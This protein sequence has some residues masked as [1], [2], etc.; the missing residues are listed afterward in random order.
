MTEQAVNEVE[1]LEHPMDSM[2]RQDRLPHIWC[3]GCGI[4]TAFSAVI[5]TIKKSGTPADKYAIVSGIGCS[6]RSAGYLKIDSFHTTH[7]RSIPFATG[8]KLVKPEMKVFVFAGDG[9]LFAIGGNHFIH[10]ARRNLD[11]TVICS[12]NYIYGM[13]GGQFSPGTPKDAISSTSPYGNQDTPFSFVNLAKASGAVFVAR[14]TTTHLPQMQKAIS[15]AFDKRG[16]SFVEII[17]PC[18]TVYGR[19]NKQRLGV[20]MMRALK[21]NSKI[22]HKAQD[23]DL[24]IEIGKPIIL[25]NFVDKERETFTDRMKAMTERVNKHL[26]EKE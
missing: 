6:S 2:L 22:D 9:D 20:Q 16:F 21:E 23:D 17:N 4:G 1:E 24:N 3:P 14:W 11:I 5:E 13:T 25:G 18:P 8:L 26:E 10:A 19:R 12:N 7:G 15:K